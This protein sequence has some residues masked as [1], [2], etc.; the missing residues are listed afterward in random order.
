[1]YLRRN[2]RLRMFIY[3]VV[4]ISTSIP[5]LYIHIFIYCC[6][7]PNTPPR[8]IIPPLGR[9][10]YHHR[11]HHLQPKPP[12]QQSHATVPIAATR[13][14]GGRP[15]AASYENRPRRHATTYRR[16]TTSPP[17]VFCKASLT[18][19]SRARSRRVP[20]SRPDGLDS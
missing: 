1:M 14:G 8:S 16:A 18:C 20:I 10:H 9:C 17:R 11:R 7:S 4:Y 12:R 5:S 19:S 2:G 15:W 3:A 6:Y 13:S